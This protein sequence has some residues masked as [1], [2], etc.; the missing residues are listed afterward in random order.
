MFDLVHNNRKV[1]QAILVVI[2]LPFAF[3]GIESFVSGGGGSDTVAK[4]GKLSISQQ[5]LQKAMLEQQ[6]RIRQQ[7]GKDIP[8]EML[9]SPELRRSVLDNL[10]T[11]RVLLQHLGKANLV[12]SDQ[13]LGAAIQN[14]PAF[15]E[16]GKFSRAHYDAYVAGQGLPP[17]EFE[18]RLRQDLALQQLVLAVREGGLP[19]QATADRWVQA[20]LEGRR[21]ARVEL[22]PE[23]FVSQVK[24]AADAAKTYYEANLKR[25]EMPEQLKADYL[26]LSLDALQ[27]QIQVSE[28][29]V[30]DWYQS[31]AEQYKQP[32][33]REA[34]HILI[35]VAQDADAKTVAAA[36]SR[37]K[38]LLQALRSKPADFARLARENSQD[39]G[40]AAQGG[41]LGWFAHGAMVKPFDDAVFAL[42]NGEISEP[43]RSE[44][45]FH[46]IQ[47]TGIKP[48][49]VQPLTAV[50]DEIAKELKHQ[51]AMRKYSE[52]AESFSNLVYEQADSLQPA[53]EKSGMTIQ[54]G[55]WITR[56]ADQASSGLWKNQRLLEALFSDDV[57]KDKHNTEAIEVAPN[58]LVAA[59]VAEYK[60]AA[61]QA[62]D[63]VEAAIE[64][65]LINEQAAA[66]AVKEGTSQL[67]RLQQG[68]KLTLA[69]GADRVLSRVQPGDLSAEAVNAVFAA[70]TKKLPAYVGVKEATGGYALYRIEA[71]AE[72][73]SRMAAEGG[74]QLRDAYARI[75]AEVDQ[76]AWLT[77]LRQKYKVDIQDK[78]LASGATP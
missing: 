14:I 17:Q 38:T 37:A 26:V 59:R 67:A 3:F 52:L 61:R 27:A 43:V 51:A 2:T 11:Q 53:A 60:P 7:Y 40:S 65:Q 49:A 42:K 31:H 6:D 24:L 36:E 1:V 75:V 13:Q 78:A 22:K 29:E 48:A 63:T 71:L 4:V 18:R 58:T 66:L 46:I 28:K 57:L 69:W 20:M 33:E 64:R 39:P 19:A 68:E 54:H 9:N 45:G 32:E 5:D 35:T 74:R 15:Q 70:S 8:Q 10:I 21:L 72:P 41:N 56:Q 30:S 23:Q 62:F 47:L 34:S 76:A 12:V 55:D 73:D 44:F 77:S 16:D 50:H 25:F